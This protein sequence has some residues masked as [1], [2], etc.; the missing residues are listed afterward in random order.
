MLENAQSFLINFVLFFSLILILL[1][2]KLVHSMIPKMKARVTKLQNTIFWNGMIR[3]FMEAYLDFVLFSL[4]NIVEMQWPDNIGSIAISNY[5]SILILTL[6]F[7]TPVFL[8]VFS[9]VNKDRWDDDDYSNKYSSF[10]QGTKS[11]KQNDY[12]AAVFVKAMFFL[13]RLA[14]CLTL[15]FWP[16][17]FWGQVAM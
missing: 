5:I 8:I 3:L 11:T 4:L 7:M 1:M 13:R 10:L 16:T 6:C 17:F 9:C 2:L 15:V 12:N 14:L